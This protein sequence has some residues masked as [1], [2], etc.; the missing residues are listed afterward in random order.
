MLLRPSRR[1][2][3]RGGALMSPAFDLTSYQDALTIQRALGGKDPES[4][5]DV[6]TASGGWLLLPT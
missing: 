6:A 3:E 2:G 4:T 1:I 5:S